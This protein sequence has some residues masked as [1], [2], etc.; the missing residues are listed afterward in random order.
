MNKFTELNQTELNSVSGGY[1]L[2]AEDLAAI[3]FNPDGGDQFNDPN[4]QEEGPGYVPGREATLGRN[5]AA[6]I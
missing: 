1:T 6:G 3:G 2:T 4:P 5:R